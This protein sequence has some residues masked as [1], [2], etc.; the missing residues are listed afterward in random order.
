[1]TLAELQENAIR[2]GF[3]HHFV[4]E[5]GGVRCDGSGPVYA[6]AD[7]KIVHSNSV[8]AG[9]DP[10][11]EATLYMIEARDGTKGMMIIPSSFHADPDKA[12]LIDELR[13]NTH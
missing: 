8:D 2:H 10:G 1:M 5:A 6:A 12:Q 9:T 13:K 3:S 11:D 4:Y 7:L